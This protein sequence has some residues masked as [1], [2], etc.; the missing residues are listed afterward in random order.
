MKVQYSLFWELPSFNYLKC[1]LVLWTIINCIFTRKQKHIRSQTMED[2]LFYI[3]WE[4]LTSNKIYAN[5]V[6]K[7]CIYIFFTRKLENPRFRQKL[8]FFEKKIH[9]KA[10]SVVRQKTIKQF[11]LIHGY[12]ILKTV[13]AT[14][15]IKQS[16]KWVPP[17]LQLFPTAAILVPKTQNS[18]FSFFRVHLF[19]KTARW[20]IF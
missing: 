17:F 12:G 8:L 19:I 9:A 4:R 3:L 7:L 2:K 10:S 11:G 6:L 15:R 14:Q 13:S 18:F 16:E 20:Y 1:G 5:K